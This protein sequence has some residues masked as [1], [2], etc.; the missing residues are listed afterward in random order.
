ME[1]YSYEKEDKD[2]ERVKIKSLGTDEKRVEIK[3]KL[4]EIN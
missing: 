3:I 2:I 4:K 1:K